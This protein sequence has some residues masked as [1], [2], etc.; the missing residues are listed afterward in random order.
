MTE[1]LNMAARPPPLFR[2]HTEEESTVSLYC[3]CPQWQRRT[4]CHVTSNGTRW[5]NE[6]GQALQICAITDTADTNAHATTSPVSKEEV[7]L[8]VHK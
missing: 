4:K 8:Q 2:G 7:C 3:Q 5:E 6:M 1:F